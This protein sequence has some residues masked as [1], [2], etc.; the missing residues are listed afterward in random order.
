MSP[1]PLN[2]KTVAL[3]VC[4]GIAAYKACD[5]ASKLR[6]AGSEVP[7]IMT[8]SF[9][10]LFCS[11]AMVAMVMVEKNRV[12]SIKCFVFGVVAMVAMGENRSQD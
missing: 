5:L 1:N 9:M 7:V 2:N 12:C 6:Q 10:L 8:E 3:G 11:A 4:G